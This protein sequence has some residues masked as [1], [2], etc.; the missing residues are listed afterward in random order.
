ML[1]NNKEPE[2]GKYQSTFKGTDKDKQ[3]SFIKGKLIECFAADNLLILKQKVKTH[4]EHA[5]YIRNAAG[6]DPV[7]KSVNWKDLNIIFVF[8]I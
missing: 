4:S 3:V 2:I 6:I 8:R 5:N 7:K 1:S